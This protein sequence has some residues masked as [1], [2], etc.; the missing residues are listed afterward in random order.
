MCSPC[1]SLNV[2]TKTKKIENGKWGIGG[3]FVIEPYGGGCG[4]Q[5]LLNPSSINR[6][7]IEKR[8]ENKQD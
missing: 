4:Q 8:T 3:G 1:F 7:Q 6:S 2:R 5:S